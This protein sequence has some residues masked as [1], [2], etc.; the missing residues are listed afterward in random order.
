MI[1]WRARVQTITELA[2]FVSSFPGSALPAVTRQTISLLILDL[3]GAAAAG[4]RSPLADAA[5]NAAV[6]AYG[7]GSIS[8]WLTD[9][10]TSVVG[11]AMA[12]S[13]AASALDIDDGHRGAGGHAGAGVIP[14]AL[15]VAQAV[16]ASYS[17]TM[18]AI[19]LGY[20]IALRVA[21]SR[22][23]ETVDTYASGRWVGYGAAAAA[24]RLLGLGATE[25]A[26][27]LAIAGSEGPVVF[28]T[29]SA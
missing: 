10:Q 6:E 28:S 27:A 2:N 7:E 9:K 17:E 18:V 20:E 8:I 4:L 25:T 16:D 5:R 21:S 22:P 26:H 29:A 23:I 24:C 13:A 19:A 11:A 3:I 12:N 1:Y 14:A 15:A